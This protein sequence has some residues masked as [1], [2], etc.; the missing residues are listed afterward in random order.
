MPS[1]RPLA[2]RLLALLLA[3][4]GVSALGGGA[5]LADPS[6]A[7]LRMPLALLDG[8]PFADYRL[9]G[10]ALFF[11]LGIGPLTAAAAVVRRAAW[12]W[13][14]AVLTGPVLIA[15]IAIQMLLIGHVSWL[16]PF[17]G[18]LGLAL[19]ALAGSGPV[20]GVLGDRR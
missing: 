3:F 4:Q 13:L 14:A 1:R 20:R 12:A 10:A 11:V 17:Y 5:L 6:G 2:L 19:L 18:A 16:Q 15:W 8:T 9:P 7:V